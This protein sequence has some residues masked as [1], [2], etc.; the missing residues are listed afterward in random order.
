MGNYWKSKAEKDLCTLFV[1]FTQLQFH[2][3]KLACLGV[4]DSIGKLVKLIFPL[5]KGCLAF[6]S[7]KWQTS[8]LLIPRN[9]KDRT[10]LITPT[11]SIIVEHYTKTL[12]FC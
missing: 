12:D 4:V 1:A 8:Q 10:I 7:W 2:W 9:E 6:R 3:M 11:A 5:E